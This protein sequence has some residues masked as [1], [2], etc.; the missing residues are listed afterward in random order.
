MNEPSAITGAGS[1]ATSSDAT[2]QLPRREVLDYLLGLSAIAA[3]G[4]VVYPIVRF[5]FPP[6]LAE[7]AASGSVEAA[8]VSEV[9]A[10]TAKIFPLGTRP[11][12]LVHTQTGEWRAFS[13][14]CTH[15]SCTVRF[16]PDSQSIWCPCHDG[17]FDLRGR[18]VGGPPPSPL[19]QHKVSVRGDQV[20]VLMEVMS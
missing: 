15:L 8:K 9:P 4:T 19:P 10:G 18:N 16:K 7:K 20:Y 1:P 12:I 13:A 11:G 3:A 6:K 5:V 14:V 17:Q 2:P